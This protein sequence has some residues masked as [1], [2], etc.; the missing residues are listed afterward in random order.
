MEINELIK[1]PAQLKEID[2]IKVTCDK[3]DKYNPENPEINISANVESE[4]ISPE[5]GETHIEI[6][7]NGEGFNIHLLEKGV[8]EFEGIVDEENIKRFLEVQGLRL[9]WSYVRETIFDFSGKLLRKPIMLPTID[10]LKTIES[11]EARR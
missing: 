4:I 1:H 3:S 8:F 11:A 6:S 10:V 7:I 9:M 5:K 2:L